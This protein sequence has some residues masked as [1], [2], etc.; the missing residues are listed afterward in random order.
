MVPRQTVQLQTQR[1]SL[2]LTIILVQYTT[3][4]Q[5]TCLNVICWLARK[6]TSSDI[7]LSSALRS[8]SWLLLTLTDRTWLQTRYY[9]PY[10]R[11]WQNMFKQHVQ[12]SGAR[13]RLS[14][15]RM[16]EYTALTLY[17]NCQNELT[18]STLGSTG[19]VFKFHKY[20]LQAQ[21]L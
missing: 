16:Y 4:S 7:S 12:Y 21:K 3:S 8:N 20:F 19:N 14:K 9:W 11:K 2:H 13:I 6:F 15:H 17:F 18:A 5:E 10:V 1:L